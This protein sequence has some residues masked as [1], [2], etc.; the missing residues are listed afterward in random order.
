MTKYYVLNENTLI[1]SQ[2]GTTLYGVLAGKIQLGGHDWLNGPI[3]VGRLDVLRAATLED[4][5]YFRVDPKGH[6]A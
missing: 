4:F 5:E 3:S 1:Y 2:E 6:I